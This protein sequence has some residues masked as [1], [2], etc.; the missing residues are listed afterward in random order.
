MFGFNRRKIAIDRSE[1]I[2]LIDQA[3]SDIDAIVAVSKY[4]RKDEEPVL[5][6]I[7]VL[8]L[9]RASTG[10]DSIDYNETRRPKLI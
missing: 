10:K 7:R 9:L 1:L 2:R 4:K 5:N 8:N 3:L 6:T